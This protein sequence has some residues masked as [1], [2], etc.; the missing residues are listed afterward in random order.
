[1]SCDTAPTSCVVSIL[2]LLDT[3]RK[4]I[5]T[6]APASADQEVSI[7]VLLDT[8][9]KGW[10]IRAL[11][12]S[13]LGFNP[14][15]SGSPAGK[16]HPLVGLLLHDPVSI[17][18]LLDTG[19]KVLATPTW[20]ISLSSFNPCS[21]GYRPA[22]RCSPCESARFIVVSILVLLDTGRKGFQRLRRATDDFFVSILVLLDTG[23]KGSSNGGSP[24]Y[25]V[26]FQ[27][28][29]FWIPAG[30]TALR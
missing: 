2:V 5:E 24:Y 18:V 21:S 15:S 27:S 3:G 19:R 14:C 30:K 22:K 16:R 7:L 17:L 12:F 29:F 25:T 9:R 20:P 28:L 1:M 23:R 26:G 8:G 6:A 11:I 13:M 10:I 4:G